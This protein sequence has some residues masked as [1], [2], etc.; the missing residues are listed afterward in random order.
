M[1]LPDERPTRVVLAE[2]RHGLWRRVCRSTFLYN[3]VIREMIC[4]T[5]HFTLLCAGPTLTQ[6]KSYKH[7]QL[8]GP[9]YVATV[10]KQKGTSV[11]DD[12]FPE[13]QREGNESR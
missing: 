2:Q 7:M 12:R 4:V 5:I 6:C 13:G 1:Q 10:Q 11:T 8:Q 3:E 9:I